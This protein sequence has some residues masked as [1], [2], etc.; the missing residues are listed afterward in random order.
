[1]AKISNQQ[2][3]PEDKRVSIDDYLIGTDKEDRLR[4][5]TY[6]MKSVV[7]LVS[8]EIKDNIP[9]KT[10]E[11]INDGEDGIN[12]FVS[13]KDLNGK[14]YQ[15][16]NLSEIHIIHGLKRYVYPEV[17]INSER[18]ITDVEYMDDLDSILIRLGKPETGIV[19][20]K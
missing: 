8:E 2:V 18:V 1:M 12:P 3:Y 13:Q 7:E 19:I 17:I 11:L 5:K 4:T 9:R 10:S 6:P 16:S 14:V 15:F 20:L